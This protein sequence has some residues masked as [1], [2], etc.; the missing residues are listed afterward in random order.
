MARTNSSLE[1]MKR[2]NAMIKEQI[3]ELQLSVK[4]IG[5]ALTKLQPSEQT[6]ELKPFLWTD[7]C[8]RS[9]LWEEYY[10]LNHWRSRYLQGI[11]EVD[12]KEDNDPNYVLRR[13]AKIYDLEH[14]DWDREAIVALMQ[15]D[16]WECVRVREAIHPKWEHL[17]ERDLFNHICEQVIQTAKDWQVNEG[18]YT[19]FQ[20]G[21]F[22]LSTEFDQE[23]GKFFRLFYAPVVS[24]DY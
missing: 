6:K 2:E 1:E 16:I 21:E 18:P 9:D 11:E 12:D 19:I 20:S 10:E 15:F 13:L 7:M 23:C 4:N 24:E 17:S 22:Y 8:V 5:D 3:K 14:S